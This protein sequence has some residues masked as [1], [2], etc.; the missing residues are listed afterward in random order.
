MVGGEN[1][2]KLEL[3]CALMEEEA[4]GVEGGRRNICPEDLRRLR[5]NSTT[6]KKKSV[7]EHKLMQN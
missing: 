3:T 7:K 2:E 4:D 6:I 1:S 5:N